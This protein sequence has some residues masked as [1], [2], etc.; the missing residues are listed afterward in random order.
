[1]IQL[2]PISPPPHS[3]QAAPSCPRARRSAAA[4]C[5]STSPLRFSLAGRA[6]LGLT[7]LAQVLLR[8]LVSNLG[9]QRFR[10][11][12]GACGLDSTD[13]SVQGTLICTTLAVVVTQ[14]R[15]SLGAFSAV[16]DRAAPHGSEARIDAAMP[17]QAPCSH[18][19]ASRTRKEVTGN[20]D[21]QPCP[22]AESSSDSSA[23]VCSDG[24]V[25]SVTVGASAVPPPAAAPTPCSKLLSANCA[26]VADSD[27][28]FSSTT[29]PTGVSSFDTTSAD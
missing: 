20:I 3:K 22:A 21:K 4:A 18:P 8:I 11:G 2:A 9:I 6:G 27:I 26:L 10:F 14:I 13:C 17:S 15:T 16:N 29:G 25:H 28:P 23:A 19:G 12:T 5:R 24:G 7:P 1:M